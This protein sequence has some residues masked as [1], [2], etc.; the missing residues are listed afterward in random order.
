MPRL[1]RLIALGLLP[2]WLA[3]AQAAEIGVPPSV[4]AA[5]RTGGLP[6][7]AVSILVQEAAAE[8][9]LLAL[10]AER[11]MA[12]ASVMKLVTTYAGLEML[13]PALTGLPNSFSRGMSL[14][15]S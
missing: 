13:G 4:E 15:A 1:L 7:D 2:A 6:S 8:R 9:A 3:T 10:N 5:I 11:A 14:T 12:P